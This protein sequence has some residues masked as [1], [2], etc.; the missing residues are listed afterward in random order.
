MRDQ[1]VKIRR[2][3]VADAERVSELLRE[4]AL[5]FIVDEF[6]ELG[7]ARYLQQLAPKA[8]AKRL[9]GKDFRCLVAEDAKAMVGFAA[10][11]GNWHLY[12]LVV[13]KGYQRGGLARRLWQLLRDEVLSADPPRNFKANVPRYAVNAYTRLGFQVDGAVRA[14]KGVC[15]QPMTCPVVVAAPGSK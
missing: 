9:A 1:V 8:T 3:T 2:A 11:Q 15:F 6:D 4:I 12:H 14:E 5:E 13:A 7:R 10:L